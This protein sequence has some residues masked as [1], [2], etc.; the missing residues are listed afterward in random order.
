[1]QSSNQLIPLVSSAFNHNLGI[2]NLGSAP[3]EDSLVSNEI[4]KSSFRS[5]SFRRKK[6]ETGHI[7]VRILERETKLVGF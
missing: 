5:F 3:I 2:E 7:N 6:R 1:M 4:P